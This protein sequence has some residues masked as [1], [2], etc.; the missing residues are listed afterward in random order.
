MNISIK[1]KIESMVCTALVVDGLAVTHEHDRLRMATIS[2]S[3][4]RTRSE[5][6]AGMGEYCDSLRQRESWV[7]KI[8]RGL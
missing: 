5:P 4:L 2:A 8:N 3:S 6:W 1:K 7:V